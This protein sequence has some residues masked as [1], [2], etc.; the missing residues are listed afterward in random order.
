MK[1]SPSKF[2]KHKS[3]DI[4]CALARKVDPVDIPAYIACNFAYARTELWI[5]DLNTI[6]A[7]ERYTKYRAYIESSSYNFSEDMKK[8]VPLNETLKPSGHFYPTA[9]SY[10]MS[11]RIRIESLC[12]LDSLYGGSMSAAWDK[13]ISERYL[14]PTFYLRM[15][16]FTPWPRLY[17]N[18]D[19]N[20]KV[21]DMCMTTK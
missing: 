11:G 13:D 16:K 15:R 17:W 2:E 4:F 5:G 8:L 12:I 6:E 7:A 18:P 14:W 21:V 10:A 1:T 3:Y 19:Q 20:K 9:V